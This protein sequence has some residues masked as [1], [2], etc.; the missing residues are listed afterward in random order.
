MKVPKSKKT[1]ESR[2]GRPSTDLGIFDSIAAAV[3]RTGIPKQIWSRAKRDG[4]PAFRSNRVYLEAF[5]RWFFGAGRLDEFV[6]AEQQKAENQRLQNEKLRLQLRQMNGE[7]IPVDELE[8][9]EAEVGGMV[10]SV[11]CQLHRLAP[12]L[13]GLPVKQIEDQ[14]KAAEDDVLTQLHS[15][16]EKLDAWQETAAGRESDD[17]DRKT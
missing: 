10:R 12:A 11:V 8:G 3:A 7:L 16:A 6:D 13:E 14:L 15:F 2:T 5:L 17:D 1:T 4:C 9:W